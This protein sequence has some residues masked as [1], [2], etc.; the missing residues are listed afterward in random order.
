MI[1]APSVINGIVVVVV[2]GM[3]VVDVV[4]VEVVVVG[5]MVDVVVVEA[6]VV[7]VVV[8]VVVVVAARPGPKVQ[9]VSAGPSEMT[10]TAAQPHLIDIRS[11]VP[12]PLSPPTAPRLVT[13]SHLVAFSAQPHRRVCTVPI[14][15]TARS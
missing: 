15:G 13:S 8:A 2:G 6:T 5:G 3:V 11:T 12:P 10:A 9:E 4:V 7:D 14:A 1:T